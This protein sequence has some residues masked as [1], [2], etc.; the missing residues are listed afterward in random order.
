MSASDNEIFFP[1]ADM[2]EWKSFVAANHEALLE[3]N[4]IATCF[5]LA[6]NQSLMIGG[7]ASQLF[8]VGF[9]DAD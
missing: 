5:R 1:I 7:G 6:C 2:D 9:I 8:R 4:D 3:I